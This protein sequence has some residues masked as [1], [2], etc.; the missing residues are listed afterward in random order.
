[1]GTVSGRTKPKSVMTASISR[2]FDYTSPGAADEILKT[3]MVDI[4]FDGIGGPTFDLG[5]RVLKPRGRMVVYGLSGGPVAPFDINRLSGIAGFAE[6]G[7][8]SVTWATMSDWIPD[9]ASLEYHANAVFRA[10]AEG[11]LPRFDVVTLPLG[12]AMEAHRTIES[13]QASGKYL[14][15]P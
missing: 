5:L 14:L 4:V 15:L 8:L 10:L 13:R 3:G 11:V 6:K 9:Q 12:D 1:M 7:S 2:V